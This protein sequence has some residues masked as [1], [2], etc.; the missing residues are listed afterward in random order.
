M[1]VTRSG[2]HFDFISRTAD[3]LFP[4][5]NSQRAYYLNPNTGRFWTMDTD[6]GDNEDPLS[7]HKYLYSHDDPVDN[8]DPTGNDIE[9]MLD[10]MEMSGTLDGIGLP[11]APMA[12]NKAEQVVADCV[13]A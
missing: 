11:M 6:V 13:D 4:G 8:D 12:Q 1:A 5:K 9:G 10:V 7:L 2:A 3:Y